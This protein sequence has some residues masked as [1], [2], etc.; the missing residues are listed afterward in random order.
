MNA[1]YDKNAALVVLPPLTRCPLKSRS[2][3]KWLAR[4]NH[5]Y[6]PGPRELLSRVV[7]EL[8]LEYP[9]TGLAA[10]RMWGQTGDKPSSWIAAADPVYLEPMLDHLR[11]HDVRQNKIDPRHFRDLIDRLQSAL[12]DDSGF[13]FTR[14]GSCGYL[15]AKVPVRTA[16]V[17]AYIVEG[18][19]PDDFLPTGTDAAAFLGLVSE[20]EMALHDHEANLEREAA[21]LSPINSLWLWGGGYASDQSTRPSLPLISDDPLLLGYWYSSTAPARQ[22][23]GSIGDCIE[24]SAQGFVAA[25]PEFVEDSE[26]IEQCLSEL[27]AALRK[28]RF[29]RLVLLFRDGYRAELKRHHCLRIWR[30]DSMPLSM[31]PAGRQSQ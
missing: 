20:I 23:R 8:A 27:Q 16:D 25:L 10:L 26:L 21:G 13:G 3:R 14:L 9:T 12:S 22:W 4:S 1:L 19:R 15:S 31:R 24:E 6:A 28:Q 11:L 5:S 18:Q 7:E 2:L 30:G 29:S 17:P